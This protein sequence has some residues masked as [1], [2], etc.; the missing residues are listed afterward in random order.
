MANFEGH[1]NWSPVRILEH[2]EL[3]RGGINGNMNEQAK[4]L[5]ERTE[6]LMEE[7]ASKSEIVQG[8]YEFN[9]YAE[10]NAIKSTLPLNCTVIIN[11]MPT[12][13]QTWGQGTNRWNGTTLSKSAYDP[14]AQ[15][16]TE[17]KNYADQTKL[18]ISKIQYKYIN[19]N[20]IGPKTKTVEGKGLN[21]ALSYVNGSNYSSKIIPILEGDSIFLL[22]E[23]QNYAAGSGYGYAFFDKDPSADG[24]AVRIAHT[25][26]GV[27][28]PTT[29]LFYRRV[30]APTGAKFLVLNSKFTN[31]IVWAVHKDNFSSNYTSGTEVVTG[32]NGAEIEKQLPK[33]AVKD[34]NEGN[35][36]VGD[37]FTPDGILQDRYV[38]SQ[39]LLGNG[40]AENNWK[41]FRFKVN[42][43]ED[44]FLKVIGPTTFPF[45]MNFSSSFDTVGTGTNLGGVPLQLTDRENI[46]KFTA[47][48][49]AVAV[50]MSV[51][52]DTGKYTLNLMD[53]LS[54]QNGEFD[55]AY[56]GKTERGISSI[57]NIQIVDEEARKALRNLN[58]ETVTK[59]RFS[60]KKVIALG[61]SI[62]AGTQ[63]GYLKYLEAAFDTVVLNH[64]SSGGR[65]GRVFDQV[66]AG[67]G[68]DRRNSSTAGTTW[69][70]IDFTNTACVTLMIGTNDSD[71]S[72]FGAVTDIP[73]TNFSDHATLAE[74]AA[75]FPNNYLANIAFV[76]EYIRDKAPMAEIHVITP[77]YR[78]DN[79]NGTQ[80]ITKLIPALEAVSRYY[81]VHL[82]YATYESGIGFKEM[83]GA[84]NIYSYD[85]I[86]FNEQG[87][88]VFGKFVARKILSSS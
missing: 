40:S 8:H 67:E 35:I 68:L 31:P 63:G 47:V 82:I 52:V 20:V 42:V 41:A 71:G 48:D 33:S 76:I 80:R 12:G 27:T 44:Y 37:I 59:T 51:K 86:H 60:G 36:Q 19:G 9:T 73:T 23:A 49:G 39:G 16:V 70:V 13:T 25:S 83:N 1:K 56:V 61:D 18:D 7:K 32:L 17:A 55:E 72:S 69:P 58:P 5:T 77:P 57:N 45:K 88:E 30:Y 11:E 22:N 2:S 81:G 6:L 34:I 66:V 78:Y 38:T 84:L 46:Y 4:A 10:F 74:Y 53:T 3:A 54:I 43:G 62:T 65:A 15:A 50:F 29:S 64:G 14:K 85:G 26:S 75:L 24:T 21:S 87:N 28:D 79:T